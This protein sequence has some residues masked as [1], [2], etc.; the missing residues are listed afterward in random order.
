MAWAHTGTPVSATWDPDVPAA[1]LRRTV[2]GTADGLG[3]DGQAWRDLVGVVAPARGAA[4]RRDAR[5]GRLADRA[6]AGAARLRGP[7]EGLRTARMLLEPVEA[8]VA[9]EFATDA[10]RMLFAANA[11]H[12]DVGVDAAGSTPPA[13]LLAMAAQVHGMPVPVGGAVACW[14]RRWWRPPRRPA[15]SCGRASRSPGSSCAAA[16]RSA[17]SLPTAR[18]S[19]RAA[20]SSPTSRRRR[21]PATW[22]ARSTCRGSGWPRCGGTATRRGYFRVDVDLDRPGAVGGRAAGRQRRRA[23]HRRPRRAGHVAGRG[24]ARAAARRT[25]QL[26]L[27]QQDRADPT[28]V[29]PARRACGWSATA[30]RVPVDAAADWAPRFTDRVLDRLE[31]HAPGLRSAVVDTTTLT[32]LDLQ[33]RDPNLVGG[34]VG[35]GLRRAGP[36]SGLPA[37]GGLVAVRPA[38][39]RAVD[40]RRGVPPRRRGARAVRPQRRPG[41]APQDAARV[42]PTPWAW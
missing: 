27:G 33:D 20:P 26:I 35:G 37:G 8:Y 7:R 12:A 13:M 36:A 5:A 6:A 2:D 1:V 15:S 28:R 24:A 17:S 32:P 38:G 22:S 25:P 40:V 18:G 10:G 3:A 21:W 34:D 31:R 9:Q 11:T 19:P 14:R 4:V 23:R 42:W 16:G 39:R 30:R 29:P 41:G